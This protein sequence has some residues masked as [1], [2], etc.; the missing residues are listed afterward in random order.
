MNFIKFGM[1]AVTSIIICTAASAN[2][3]QLVCAMDTRIFGAREAGLESIVPAH[4]THVVKSLS[5]EITEIS[6]VGRATNAGSRIKFT[7]SGTLEDVGDVIITYTYIKS[8]GAMI[9]RTQ[10]IR[11][12]PWYGMQ[13]PEKS[14]EFL[15][16][17]HCVMK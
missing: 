6:M 17:G 4:A 5:A 15:I 2:D 10:A 9:A 7:Y 14:G 12:T 1:T 16:N 8:T 11:S 13:P 3:F